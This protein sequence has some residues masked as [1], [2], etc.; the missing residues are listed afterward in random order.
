MRHD[1]LLLIAGVALG[2]CS[3]EA[4]GA[5]PAQLGAVIKR[6]Q[7]FRDVQVTDQEEQQLGEAVSKKIRVRYGVVQD[8]AVHKYVSLVGTILA[9]SGSRPNLSYHF[10]VLDT[11]G[12]NAFA[13]GKNADAAKYLKF[14]RDADPKTYSD[15]VDA[16]LNR[17]RTAR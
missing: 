8:A 15:K 3:P 1:V 5:S 4:Q 10:M 6:A 9:E 7:Q 16:L 11:D 13:A 14:A 17:I 12:V 2:M